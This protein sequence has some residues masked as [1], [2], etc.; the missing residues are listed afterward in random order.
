MIKKI[1]LALLAL[2]LVLGLL[3]F[4]FGGSLVNDGIRR[5]VVDYGPEMT[6]T[7]VALEEVD[8]SAFD[9]TG[10]I[11]GLVVGN[12]PGFTTEKAMSVGEVEVDLVPRSLLGET[13]EIRRIAIEA[14][15]IV[16]ERA[17]GTTNL[18][19]IQRNIE[20]AI[21][22]PAP[23]EEPPAEPGKKLSIEE[24]VI[25]NAH[26]T[27]AGF[28]MSRDLSLPTIRLTELGT[29]EGGVP[30]AEIAR[31]VLQALTREVIRQGQ[32]LG[33]QFLQDPE[34]SLKEVQGQLENL[35]DQAGGAAGALRNLLGGER[36][37]V[38]E[39]PAPAGGE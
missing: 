3:L 37:Q 36:K 27:V 32:D 29:E 2:V 9:G 28:G 31:E 24:F 17:Q 11:S 19:Q 10:R 33:M 4:F 12:P 13:I 5:V 25:E 35:R 8:I 15:E 1:L 30:P 26:V 20:E 18:Q 21:G 34:G 23:E 39:E 6:G 22:P 14:P 16:F 38:E 7:S